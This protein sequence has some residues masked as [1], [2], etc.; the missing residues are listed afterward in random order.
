MIRRSRIQSTALVA[1]LAVLG[2]SAGLL[3]WTT[4]MVHDDEGYVLYSLQAYAT[5]G[6]LYDQVYSQYGPFFF[7]LFRALH[8]L[9]VAFTN[10]GGREMAWCYWIGSTALGGALVWR[11]TGGSFTATL[12]T[13]VAVFGHLYSMTFEPSH[14]GGLIALLTAFAAWG[15]TNEHWPAARRAVLIGAIA[16]MLLLTKINVGVFFVA[17]AGSW[18]GLQLDG[19]RGQRLRAAIVVLLA[20]MPLLLMR[21][22]LSD[23]WVRMFVLVTGCGA[24]AVVAASQFNRAA[25]SLVARAVLQATVAGALVVGVT[26]AVTLATGTTM[27]QL[28]DGII[29]DPL[30]QPSVYSFAFNWRAGTA[31]IAV[32]GVLLALWLATKPPARRVE[33]I[34][35]ARIAAAV[36]Y[37]FCA[38]EY[39]SIGQIGFAL[40]FGVATAWVFVLPIRE[41]DNNTGTRA[42]LALLLVTQSLHAYP[43]PGSQIAWGTFLWAPLVAIGICDIAK[44]VRARALGW[45]SVLGFGGMSL[46]IAANYATVSY[47][48]FMAR[49]EL[50]LAGAEHLRPPAMVAGAIRMLVRNAQVHGD[51]LFSMP[52]M[53]SFNL[54]AGLPTPTVAN[55]TH[56]FTL[57]SASQQDQIQRR[58]AADPRAVIIVQRFILDRLEAEHRRIDTPLERW[59]VANY[60]RVFT[61]ESYEFWVRNGRTVVPVQSAQLF[62]SSTG[63]PSKYRIDVVAAPAKDLRIDRFDFQQLN[64]QSALI[65][66]NWTNDNARY[67]VTPIDA[68]GKAAG[69]AR[70][71]PLPFVISGLCRIEIFTNAAPANV[72]HRVAA[73]QLHSPNG[74]FEDAPLI[75]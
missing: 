75:E 41:D 33:W 59:L 10:T 69:P 12:A 11:A 55:T 40:S 68:A 37:A 39:F 25:P 9:G 46:F 24:C 17:A 34:V 71:T 1:V 62:E 8:A 31:V 57:L 52:G 2:I 7:V 50:G 21:K 32:G 19:R 58:L 16:G 18:Y 28:L 60:H 44:V 47:R 63:S 26:F 54:W 27:G 45:L 66:L 4:F 15:G 48:R 51:M 6:H 72:D 67:V 53:L 49:T 43:V 73:I 56:W 30:R 42:W 13:L 74:H 70:V 36:V 64:G 65:K 3:L 22:S 61:V 38:T 5:H 35:P 14:P 29:L 23:A 20:L